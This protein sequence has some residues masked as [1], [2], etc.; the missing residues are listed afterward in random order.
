MAAPA[1]VMQ[2]P[3]YIGY[4]PGGMP[5]PGYSGVPVGSYQTQ[6]QYQP[7]QPP[8]SSPYYPS[9]GGG[10]GV[11][12]GMVAGAGGAGGAGPLPGAL[13]P[14]APPP[15]YAATPPPP[16]RPIT[17]EEV[18]QKCVQKACMKAFAVLMRSNLLS[19]CLCAAAVVQ[20][21]MRK[22]E[23]PYSIVTG[24]F[25]MPFVSVS[26]PHVW[27]ETGQGLVTDIT[28]SNPGRMISI[29][30]QSFGF[31][32]GAVKP[33]YT[34]V[35]TYTVYPGAIN[36]EM[37]AAHSR[38]LEAYLAGG[39]ESLREAVDAA[40]AKALDGSDKVEILVDRELLDKCRKQGVVEGGA[41]AVGGTQGGPGGSGG[42]GPMQVMGGAVMGGGSTAGGT[43]IVPGPVIGGGGPRAVA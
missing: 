43:N 6:V 8:A 34:R 40:V 2:Q 42:P 4:P 33:T 5:A 21:I 14:T 26:S 38:D 9:G 35:P 24:Y 41:M 15:V 25:H 23:M 19:S 36:R 10:A 13:Y 11:G 12:A 28:F 22:F 39:K 37:L 29:M 27:I 3:Q 31:Q 30:G 16:P 17:S 18:S 7:T 1:P 32:K 20:R